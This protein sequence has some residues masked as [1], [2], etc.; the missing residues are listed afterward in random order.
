MS[1][2]TFFYHAHIDSRF[3][4]VCNNIGIAQYVLVG[5]FSLLIFAKIICS[6]AYIAKRPPFVKDTDMQAGVMIM[7][8][9]YNEEK[10]FYFKATY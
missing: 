3:S 4:L 5:I 2:R 6:L 1:G 8:P 9:C 7:L 10:E